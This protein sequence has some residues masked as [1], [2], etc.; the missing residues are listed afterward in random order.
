MLITVIRRQWQEMKSFLLYI[1]LAKDYFFCHNHHE[2][3]PKQTINFQLMNSTLV[4]FCEH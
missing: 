3:H 4:W 2:C 1:Q